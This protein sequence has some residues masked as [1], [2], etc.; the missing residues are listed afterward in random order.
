MTTK[1][2]TTRQIPDEFWN[3]VKPLIPSSLRTTGREYRRKPGRGS[4]V[5]G[6]LLYEAVENKTLG[7]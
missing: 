1:T 3:K 4:L 5:K 7:I 2:L 6:K